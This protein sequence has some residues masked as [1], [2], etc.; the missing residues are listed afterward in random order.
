[1]ELSVLN[2]SLSKIA[3]LDVFGSLIWTDRYS[4]HGDF[5]LKTKAERDIILTL[6]EDFYLTI[7]E[8]NRSMIIE[9]VNLE[10]DIEDGS[11]FVVT[12]RSLASILERRIIWKQTLLN[13]SLH[14]EIRRL[15]DENAI[16]PEDPDRKISRLVF[17]DS[18]DPNV[19]SISINEQFTGNNLLDVIEYLCESNGLGFKVVLSPEN[20]FVFSLFLG[21]DRS[22]SQIENPFVAFSPHLDNL[23]ETKYFHSNKTQKTITLVG[24]EGEGSDRVTA[25]TAIPGI[26]NTDL[27][28][29]ELFTDARDVSSMVNGIQLSSSE[30]NDLL[31]Q[32]GLLKL[33]ENQSV[34]AFDGKVDP[35]VNYIY[36][37]DYFIGD[38]VQI[39]NDFGLN[40]RSRVTEVIY[41]EDLSGRNII[42]TFETLT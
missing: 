14:A 33:L 8:S 40:G 15:L 21:K 20:L 22:F 27:D 28:R 30:Y 34:S 39:E 7:K 42:P 5:E 9:S 41:S 2:K 23:S 12:G 16:N 4:R 31:V 38:I 19:L 3:I 37:T 32:R 25:Q 24:G 36:G 35:L 18:T 17:E 26:P 10:T 1:M 13:G 6:Q 11:S 29:R